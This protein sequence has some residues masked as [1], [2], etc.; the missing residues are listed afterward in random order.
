MRD[1]PERDS[2]FLNIPGLWDVAVEEYS[3]WQ[4]SQ[5]GNLT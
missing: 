3:D 2:D 1:I 5:V 4:Q